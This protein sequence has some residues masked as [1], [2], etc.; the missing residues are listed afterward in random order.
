MLS[1]LIRLRL[2]GMLSRSAGGGKN[3]KRKGGKGMKILILIAL[4]YCVVVFAGLFYMMF[5]AMAQALCG[6]S[7]DWYYFAIVGLFS[8]ALSFFFTAF[9]AKSELFEAKDNELLLSMPIKPRLILMSR[10]ATLL[11]M[12]YLFAL[13]VLIPAG[14]AWF[15]TAGVQAAQLALYIV[16]SLLFPLLSAAIACLFGWLLALL[17]AR[18][19]NKTFIT[20]FFSLAFMGCYFYFYM[21]AQKYIT[22]LLENH[23][24]IAEGMR[25]WGALF[26]LFGEGIAHAEF[27]KAALLCVLS[28][29]VFAGMTLLL[30]RGFLKTTSAG[31]RAYKKANGKIE[32]R[33]AAVS[34]AL[35]RRE[36][37]RFTSSAIYMLNCGLGL[38][39]TV[40]AAVALLIKQA[41]I[42]ALLPMLDTF[43]IS[44][45]EAALLAAVALSFLASM[46]I[47]TAPSVSLEG[48]TLWILRSMPVSAKQVLTAKLKLHELLCAI[49]TLFLSVAAAVTLRTDA[50]GW[51]A[52]VL[53]PQLFVLLSGAF[54]LMMNLLM[55]KLDWTSETVAVKQSGSVVVTMF[56]LMAYTILACVGLFILVISRQL[57]SVQLYV[58][59]F[60]LLT[61]LLCALCLLWLPGKGARRFD[62]L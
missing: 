17:T 14:L 39:L 36:L 6:T 35:L 20:V 41:D 34:S 47:I 48:K 30:G 21:N 1:K 26:C 15:M 32:A 28:L 42:R 52:L 58:L 13:L 61:A 49:P 9:T 23:A 43:G 46:D 38:I 57:L 56:G 4:L 8:F 31:S 25:G 18:V 62:R 29:A 51:A 45:G 24:A 59:L 50:L 3:G 11:L 54:G 7:Y 5:R 19:R 60:T 12:E 2:K 27:G 10:M 44:Q 53:I 33:S 55:P 22:T 40:I 37:K 16:C